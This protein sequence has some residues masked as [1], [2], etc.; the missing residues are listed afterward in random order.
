M[1]CW[2][3]P[4]LPVV[5]IAVLHLVWPLNAVYAVMLLLSYAR[6]SLLTLE[7]R[8][9]VPLMMLY[10]IWHFWRDVWC[11]RQVFILQK[12]QN[13]YSRYTLEY[14]YFV[15][16]AWELFL[17]DKR[18][19]YICIFTGSVLSIGLII[20]S[21]TCPCTT[22]SHAPC[23]VR[24]CSVVL[25]LYA[26]IVAWHHLIVVGTVA[27]GRCVDIHSSIWGVCM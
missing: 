7:R 17:I 26:C 8:Y 20:W 1:I 19:S 23:N 13:D 25:G 24:M 9:D 27:D 16:F 4:V 18:H 22:L 12:R 14:L 15:Y 21:C 3:Q 5:C 6:L 10:R 2:L 11:C